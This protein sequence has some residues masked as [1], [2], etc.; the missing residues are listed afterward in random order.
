MTS[1]QYKNKLRRQEAE[2]SRRRRR[3]E[4]V[5]AVREGRLK[6]QGQSRQVLIQA[7]AGKET[8]IALRLW[9]EA[10]EERESFSLAGLKDAQLVHW[11]S[12]F[13]APPKAKKSAKKGGLTAAQRKALRQQRLRLEK[14]GQAYTIS[15]A[16]V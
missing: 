14:A 10:E 9:G 5:R 4:L 7:L 2:R 13:F 1:Q 11:A 16:G 8:E 12:F 15:G 6:P 3:L